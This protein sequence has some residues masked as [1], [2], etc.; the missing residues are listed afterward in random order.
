MKKVL[1]VFLFFITINIYSQTSDT[2]IHPSCNDQWLDELIKTD[3]LSK[4]NR[5]QDFMCFMTIFDSLRHS[6]TYSQFELLHAIG[7]L[8]HYS[9]GA[10]SEGL[11]YLSFEYVYTNPDAFFLIMEKEKKSGM[12][13]WAK[14]IYYEYAMRSASEINFSEYIIQELESKMSDQKMK[15]W[16]L[17]QKVL[18]EVEKEHRKQFEEYYRK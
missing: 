7:R 4:E 12:K 6:K 18:K 5:A 14:M 3:S 8:S 15:S 16:L 11:F 10:F 17:F 9:D 1:T 13:N 2:I